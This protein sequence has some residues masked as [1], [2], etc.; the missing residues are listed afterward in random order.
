[1]TFS[2]CL[3][4]DRGKEVSYKMLLSIHTQDH[5]TVWDMGVDLYRAMKPS[6]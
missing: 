6:V 3:G 1:M 2:W 4:S 5:I